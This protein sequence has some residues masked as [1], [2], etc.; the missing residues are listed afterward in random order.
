MPEQPTLEELITTCRAVSGWS[1]RAADLPALAA[2]LGWQLRC[3][4]L[5]YASADAPWPGGEQAISV[6]YHRHA[7]DRVSFALTLPIDSIS[8][9]LAAAGA[10]LGEPAWESGGIRGWPQFTI[11]PRPP[12]TVLDWSPA[13]AY[14]GD[15]ATL[16]ETW[17][18]LHVVLADIDSEGE[19]SD[20]LILSHGPYYVQVQYT[21]DQK[22]VEAVAD[23]YLPG[24][25]RYTGAQLALLHQLGWQPHDSANWSGSGL[26]GEL[27][28]VFVRTLRDV[29]G[30][31]SASEVTA[32]RFDVEGRREY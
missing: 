21:A 3:A 22:F 9:D 18:R 32:R 19:E 1:W 16:A 14:E 10:L 29:F 5:D 26:H 15:P 2:R 17:E 28:A 23:C 20:T 11:R 27:A 31:G 4:G 8:A 24:Q 7:V 12:Q 25:H 6:L 30:A 13:E